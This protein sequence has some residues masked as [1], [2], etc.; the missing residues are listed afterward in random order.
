MLYIIIIND[1][2]QLEKFKEYT[3]LDLFIKKTD[4]IY[5]DIYSYNIDTHNYLNTIITDKKHN[6]SL[7]LIDI[8]YYLIGYI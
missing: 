2:K 4:S 7:K 1:S 6:I 5:N 3:Y 8:Y